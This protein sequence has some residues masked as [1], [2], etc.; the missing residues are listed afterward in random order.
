M[1]CSATETC[2]NLPVQSKRPGVSLAGVCVS[3]DARLTIIWPGA[4]ESYIE[5]R[6][7]LANYRISLSVF[8]KPYPTAKINQERPTMSRSLVS[9]K[10]LQATLRRLPAGSCQRCFTSSAHQPQGL[11]PTLPR[12]PVQTRQPMTQKRTKYNTVEEAKSRYNTGV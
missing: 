8:I 7:L 9:P 4:S 12:A 6:R 10:A 1:C 11:R 2:L 3:A 5:F